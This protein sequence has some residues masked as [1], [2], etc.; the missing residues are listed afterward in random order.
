MWIMRYLRIKVTIRA[1]VKKII[2]DSIPLCLKSM[3][4]GE[5]IESF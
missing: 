2:N 1:T 3:A 4:V 5:E